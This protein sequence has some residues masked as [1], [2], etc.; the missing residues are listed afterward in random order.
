MLSEYCRTQS[1]SLVEIIDLFATNLASSAIFGS[2]TL[3][4]RLFHYTTPCNSTQLET[5]TD[6]INTLTRKE[7]RSIVTCQSQS[8]DLPRRRTRQTQKLREGEIRQR[9]DPGGP[10][11][12]VNLVDL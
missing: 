9:R 1:F 4:S 5:L 11:V 7:K 10:I 2:K 12:L 8:R 3:K 6:P